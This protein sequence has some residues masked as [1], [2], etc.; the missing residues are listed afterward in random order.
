MVLFNPCISFIIPFTDKKT[1]AGKFKYLVQGHITG[2]GWSQH[3]HLY[4][5]LLTTSMY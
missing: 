1:E 3:N 5:L 4:I 2:K